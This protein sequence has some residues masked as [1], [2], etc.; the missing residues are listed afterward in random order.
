MKL[1]TKRLIFLLITVF[2]MLTL[3]A[4]KHL[5]RVRQLNPKQPLVGVQP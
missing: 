3:T 1:R 5:V 4:D 2:I